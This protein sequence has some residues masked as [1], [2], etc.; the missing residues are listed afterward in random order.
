MTDLDKVKALIDAGEKIEEQCHKV[1]DDQL[2]HLCHDD[3][4]EIFYPVEE[5]KEY[6]DF[7]V[8][9]LNGRKALSNT[10][11]RYERMEQALRSCLE[12]FD[13]RADADCDQ[14]GYI[15]NE[16]MRLQIEVQQALAEKKG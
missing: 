6:G 3:I 5:G 10:I 9:S 2:H 16:E 8:A 13:Q 12:Y 4:G 15:P 11:E 1:I 7:Y 14:D